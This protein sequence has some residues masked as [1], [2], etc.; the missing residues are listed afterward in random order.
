MLVRPGLKTKQNKPQNMSWKS[1]GKTQYK[2]EAEVKEMKKSQIF[3]RDFL[4][5]QLS[6]VQFLHEK[7]PQMRKR[8]I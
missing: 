6:T 5:I 8:I 2:P 4:G 3:A 1:R 7:T